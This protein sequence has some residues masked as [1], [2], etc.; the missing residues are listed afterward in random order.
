MNLQIIAG[1][2]RSHRAIEP[3]LT[4]V[5]KTALAHDGFSDVEV[6]DLREWHLPMFDEGPAAFGPEP[7]YTQ[8]RVEQWNRRI[9]EGDAYVFVTPEYNHSIPAVLKN[10]ID[11]VYGSFA[12]RHKPA[13]F[14][15]YSAG[16]MAATRAIEHLALVAVELEMMPLRNT[17][18]IPRIGDTFSDDG[19]LERSPD[20]A[21]EVM[22]DDLAW[23][24]SLLKGARDKQLS[25]GALRL[26]QKLSTLA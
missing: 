20:F 23:W 18:L 19:P 21:L 15:G 16:P 11:S 6:L 2:A 12:F 9:G 7:S 1:S 14:V 10:A 24:S 25:P 22:L 13:A 4:W 17:V 8:E 3:V 5:R 26:Y